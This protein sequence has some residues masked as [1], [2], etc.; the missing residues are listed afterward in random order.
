MDRDYADPKTVEP[1]LKEWGEVFRKLPRVD[2]VFVPGGDPGH[3]RPKALM[4]LLEKQAE[5]LRRHHP[6]GPDVGLAA[7][8]QRRSGSTSSWRSS[9]PSPPG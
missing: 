4:A 7:G 5:S 8:L 6:E 9:G 1:A 2:A 3:T